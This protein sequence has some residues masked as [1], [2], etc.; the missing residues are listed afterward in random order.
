M[1]DNIALVE[2]MMGRYD[3]A[4]RLSLQSLT[5]HRR[6]GDAAD[7]ALCLNNLGALYLDR[8]EYES[9]GAHLREGLAICERH[10][11]VSTRG[12]I[13]ANLAEIAM[14]TG[15]VAA[16]DTY[17]RRALEVAE[18]AGNRAVASWLKL[19]FVR[20]ALRR[21][22]FPSARSDL[23]AALDIAISVGR[24]SLQIAGVTCFVEILEAQGEAECARRI[25]S[26]A[27]D[28]PSTSAPERAVIRARLADW[29]MDAG[30]DA[31]PV[32]PGLELD[33]LV[34]RIVV[35]SNLAHAPLIA[36]LR[37]AR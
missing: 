13:L 20:L 16:A 1:L 5:Q 28:H 3:E 11:L 22:D 15:D 17:A 27:A 35:E 19:L 36:A 29:P 9:A 33:E 18:A 10:G 2:K 21:G 4:L 25:L 32:W 26:F 6:L 31:K 12:L 24:P 34:H 23:A 37:G 7:E 8:Q 14:K 30:A